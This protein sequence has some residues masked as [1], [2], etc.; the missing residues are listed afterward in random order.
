MKR[1]GQACPRCGGS[2]LIKDD[3]DSRLGW[4]RD[5]SCYMCGWN[6]PDTGFQPTFLRD[7]GT[8][9]KLRPYDMEASGLQLLRDEEI[10]RLW[11]QDIPVKIIADLMSL[12]KTIVRG[13]LKRRLLSD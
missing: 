1:A 8:P 10:V 5:Y 7:M 4:I 12:S 13:A 6:P 9:R 11:K 3:V 2:V